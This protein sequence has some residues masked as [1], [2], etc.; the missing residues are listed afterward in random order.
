MKT[1]YIVRH[2]KSSWDHPGLKDF[3]RPLMDEGKKRTRKVIKYFLDKR[4]S[5]DLVISSPAVRAYET[6]KLLAQGIHYPVQSIKQEACIYS[7][8]TESILNTIYMTPDDHD[9][10][11]IVGHNP[12]QTHLA[13]LFLRSGIDIL[14][15]AGVIA[16]SFDTDNW[17]KISEAQVRL[18]FQAY[19]K[20]LKK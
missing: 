12:T 18:E 8:E 5:V 6:A 2:A 11:M 20:M 10:L 19:P 17:E 1:L 14:P 15:T 7:G 16:L 3:D 9:S 13:N 4:I